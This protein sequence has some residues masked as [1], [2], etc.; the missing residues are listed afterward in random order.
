MWLSVLAAQKFRFP[1]L[2]QSSFHGDPRAPGGCP[3]RAPEHGTGWAVDPAGGGLS[4]AGFAGGGSRFRV[5]IGKRGHGRVQTE[6][7]CAAEQDGAGHHGDAPRQAGRLRRRGAQP[8]PFRK[9]LGWG[10]W[11]ARAAAA[12]AGLAMR[13]LRGRGADSQ[14]RGPGAGSRAAPAASLGEEPPTVRPLALLGA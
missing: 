5:R 8:A 10:T 14:C 6:R 12:R 2:R 3:R 4:E 13:R 11:R 7:R 9:R 1:L